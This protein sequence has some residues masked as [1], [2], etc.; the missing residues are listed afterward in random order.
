LA[1]ELE[2]EALIAV[3]LLNSIGYTSRLRG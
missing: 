2:K 3:E 1:F